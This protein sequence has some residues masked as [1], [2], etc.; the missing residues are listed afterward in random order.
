MFTI[1]GINPSSQ[2]NPVRCP[3]FQASGWLGEA[4]P[5]ATPSFTSYLSCGTEYV[6]WLSET[7]HGRHRLSNDS[8]SKKPKL[9]YRI[10]RWASGTETNP[11]KDP[12][13][14]A[15]ALPASLDHI[16][17]KPYF[18]K[19]MCV[20]IQTFVGVCFPFIVSLFFGLF[21]GPARCYVYVSLFDCG[22][23]QLCDLFFS[24]QIQS[25]AIWR[26]SNTNN[27]VGMPWHAYK[28]GR[29][30]LKRSQYNSMA[31]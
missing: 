10:L 12:I 21:A 9:L 31:S 24:P 11:A 18:R 6:T 5:S 22:L 3:K 16:E 29:Q 2:I 19:C 7:L 26:T 1:F 28:M 15:A 8:K 14:D 23:H 4:K 25:C 13:P 30:Q 17:S 27:Y 20:W